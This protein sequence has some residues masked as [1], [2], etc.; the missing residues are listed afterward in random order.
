MLIPIP[1]QVIYKNII[2]TIIAPH[3]ITDIIHAKHYNKLNNLLFLNTGMITSSYILI[4]NNLDNILNSIF[5]CSSIIHFSHDFNFN[6]KINLSISSILLLLSIY[7]NYNIF[8]IYMIFWHVPKHYNLNYKYLKKNKIQNLL[9]ILFTTIIMYS[10]C[11][12]IPEHILFTKIF[13]ISKGIIISHI[14]Y[15]EK[16]IYH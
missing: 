3:G 9:F 10:I 15:E 1:K 5:I 11:K 8:F 13:D 16:Y 2:S 6:K 7:Y 4:N 14:I 12:L